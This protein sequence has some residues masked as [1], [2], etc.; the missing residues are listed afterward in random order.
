MAVKKTELYS[1]LWASCDKLRG[2]MDASQYKDY[3]LTLLFVKYVSDKFK[4]DQYADVVIPPKGGFDDMA[5]LTGDKNIGEKMDTVI[6]KLAEANELRGVIDNAHF[7]DE[8]KLGKGQE[9]VDKLSGLI[10]IFRRPELDFKTNRAGNDDIIG[11]AYEYLMRKFA[12]ESGKSKGQFYTPAEVS[13]IL[14]KII[15]IDQAKKER[16]KDVT[17]YD[18]AC[19]SGSLLIRAADE[20]PFEVAIYGQEKDIV[21]AG[22][23]KMNLVLHN[24]AAGVIAKDNTFSSPHYFEDDDEKTTLRRFDFVVANPPFS[25]KNWRDGLLDY[26]RFTGY[27]ERPPEKNGDYAWLLHILKSLRPKGKAAVILPHGVLFRGNAEAAIRRSIIDRGY[28]KGIIGLPANLFYGTGIP[29]CIIVIDKEGAAERNGIFMIDA[30]H[31]FIKD[32]NKNRLRERDIYKIVA[33]FRQQITENK[34]SRLV[35][36]D[37]IRNKNDYNL[38]IPRYIDSSENEDLQSIEAHLRGGIPDYDVDGMASYWN[39]FGNLKTAL[40]KP[41]RDGFYQPVVGKDEAR[42]TVYSH[43]EFSRYADRVD[44]AFNKWKKQ[45]DDSLRGI[46]GKTTAKELIQFL[47][48]AILDGFKNITL[49]DKYDVYQVLL[50]YWQ[51]VMADDVFIIIQDSYKAARETVNIVEIT[52]SGKNKGK[53]KVTGWEGKLI[54]RAIIVEAFFHDEQKAIDEIEALAAEKLNELEETIENIEDGSV[55][56]DVLKDSGAIDVQSLKTKLKDTSL[57]EEDYAVLEDL[58]AK[59]TQCDE[60][61]KTLK[62]LKEVLEEK[63]Q[64]QY[65]KLT[66]KEIL[67]LLVNRKWYQAVYDGIDALYTAISHTIA[68]RVTELTARYE[69]PLPLVAE[70]A[71]EYE[72][73]VK[74]HLEKMGFTW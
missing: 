52:E 38:N 3:I 6:G 43:D 2:G 14:A 8:A 49:I 4:G 46:T 71:A 62:N 39:V 55:I 36:L 72:V 16:G 44:G 18:P 51:D 45:V 22:L 47:S 9:M 53:E 13:R 1:S 20:A 56:S 50:A 70:R 27:G 35:P 10:A 48:G 69:E 28:I 37:E 63:V 25:D 60:Y 59:K 30:S 58:L 21:T 73:K 67:E 26:D 68:N 54:P 64:N 29:A 23:A 19:G 34:Y 15:G 17:V 12:T 66:D 11:D 33:T 7:N 40:F 41:L 65:P 31:D 74:S 61:R 57:A 24:K 42:H 5:A 32:G